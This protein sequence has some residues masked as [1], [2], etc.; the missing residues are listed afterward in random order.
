MSVT[1]R[2]GAESYF[3]YDEL[4]SVT[5]MTDGSGNVTATYAYDVFGA[6]R[7]QSGSSANEWLF[8]GEQRDARTQFYYLRARY[9]NPAI[10]R[11]VGRDPLPTGNLYAYVGNN[12]VNFVDPT[13]LQ[14]TSDAALAACAAAAVYGGTA[15]A[16]GAETVVVPVGSAGGAAAVCL[17]SA[18]IAVC[19]EGGCELV[20][21]AIGALAE[22]V[23]DV[24]GKV[25]G[26]LGSKNKKPKPPIII[27][28]TDEDPVKVHQPR[29]DDFWG[30]NP[31]DWSKWWKRIVVG[32]GIT[33]FAG[34]QTRL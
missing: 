26:F 34:H 13:G 19:V 21:D 7:S 9:Y 1:G 5:G 33:W 3:L 32:G 30:G 22:G 17:G 20:G 15:A 14:G 11:F 4:G 18:L 24:A 8:T 12:P 2:T 16:A 10:G 29:F 23:S 31:P 28:Y 27:R 6:I 25:G